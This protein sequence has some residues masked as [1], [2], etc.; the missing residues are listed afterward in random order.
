[1]IFKS[2]FSAFKQP[3]NKPSAPASHLSEGLGASVI[4]ILVIDDDPLILQSLQRLLRK[5]GYRVATA[6]DAIAGLQTAI[7]LALR[8]PV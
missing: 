6:I 2:P 3:E 4:D 7:R 5:R 1:M 8:H